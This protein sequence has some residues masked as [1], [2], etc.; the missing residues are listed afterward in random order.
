MDESVS[1]D[2]RKGALDRSGV[3]IR[4][5]PKRPAQIRQ[6]DVDSCDW[7]NE[8]GRGYQTETTE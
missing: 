7:R 1:Q 6:A 8:K 5:A 2:R 4:K 3:W